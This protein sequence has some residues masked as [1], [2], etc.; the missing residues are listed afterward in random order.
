MVP[1]LQAVMVEVASDS[2]TC[3]LS[4]FSTE[5]TKYPTIIRVLSFDVSFFMLASASSTASFVLVRG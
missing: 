5:L 1:S 4:L 2:E 3:T